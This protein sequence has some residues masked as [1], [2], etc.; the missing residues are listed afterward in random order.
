MNTCNAVLYPYGSIKPLY[1]GWRC[2]M[3][4]YKNWYIPYHK[5]D[6][7][8]YTAH[9]NL[10]SSSHTSGKLPL[11]IRLME[12]PCY[13]LPFITLFH[14]AISLKYHDY[15]HILLGRGLLPK[16]EA[17]VIGF[18][19]GAT[20]QTG[21]IE[22]NLFAWISHYCYPSPF[23]F[24]VEDLQVY[25]SAVQLARTMSVKPLHNFCYEKVIPLPLKKIRLIL[26]INTEQLLQYYQDEAQK[27]NYCVESRRLI[28]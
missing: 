12:N 21:L 4:S 2:N 28:S 6:I 5:D 20:G 3:K 26:G 10:L 25:H 15:V 17:F 24:S 7:S 13:S 27:F 9:Q 18:T 11:I 14:G 1:F 16:D 19:M 8:L 23:N 22:Q